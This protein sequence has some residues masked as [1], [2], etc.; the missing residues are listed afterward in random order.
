M[1]GP[2]ELIMHSRTERIGDS[3]RNHHALQLR[4]FVMML[5]LVAQA[6]VAPVD[7]MK[8][9]ENAFDFSGEDSCF[10]FA[11]SQL[12]GERNHRLTMSRHVLSGLNSDQ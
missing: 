1:V 4:L 9:Y 6:A 2:V 11:A 12:E 7:S 5:L 8:G 3:N 10:S